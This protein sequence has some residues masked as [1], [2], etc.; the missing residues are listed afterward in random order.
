[1]DYIYRYYHIYIDIYILDEFCYMW[2]YKFLSDEFNATVLYVNNRFTV[3]KLLYLIQTKLIINI[4]VLKVKKKFG[5]KE[6]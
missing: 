1:M 6:I 3:F 5:I 4:S 2:P